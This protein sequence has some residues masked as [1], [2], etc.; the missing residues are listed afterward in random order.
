MSTAFRASAAVATS[1][2]TMPVTP[3]SSSSETSGSFTL[4]TRTSGAM[5]IASA[6]C[7][8]WTIVSRLKIECWMSMKMKS[9]PVALAMRAMSAERPRRTFMPSAA[10]P[11]CMRAFAGFTS[12]V[13]VVMADPG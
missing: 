11:A 7:A 5:P 13:S 1:G 12:L 3:L 6:V 4:R 2:N 10:S 8:M 9:C